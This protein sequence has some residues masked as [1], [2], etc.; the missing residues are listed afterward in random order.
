M[1][2]YAYTG[3]VQNVIFKKDI[4]YLVELWGADSINSGMA[5]YANG[6]I[7]CPSDTTLYLYVG[8]SPYHSTNPYAGGWNG[9]GAGGSVG[10]ST[11]QTSRGYGGGGATDLRTSTSTS[12]VQNYKILVAG[13]AGG[14][15]E[16]GAS[17]GGVGE[18][19]LPYPQQVDSD[20]EKH[21]CGGTFATESAEGVGGLA[22][23][24]PSY[25]GTNDGT[26]YV[27]SGGG[28]G[29]GYYGGGGGSTGKVYCWGSART[30][31]AGTAGNSRG[32]GGAGGSMTTGISA[33]GVQGTGGGGGGGSD[34][35]KSTYSY[36]LG[37]ATSM[38][39]G[40]RPQRP[41]FDTRNGMASV[42]P[43]LS[44]P[45]VRN[46][47]REG[48]FI[49]VTV[50]KTLNNG[51][52][53]LFYADGVNGNSQG[54]AGV[55]G[56]GVPVKLIGTES[57]TLRYS[58]QKGTTGKR[59]FTFTMTNG[60][61]SLLKTYEYTISATAPT[62][63]FNENT[64]SSKLMQ[65]GI[66]ENVFRVSTPYD[67]IDYRSES[68]LIIDDVEYPYVFSQG[69][70]QHTIQLPYLYDGINKQTY[71]LKIKT[72]AC[73][74]AQSAYG[75]G[76]DIWS[77]WIETRE[78]IVYA[79]A[80]QKNNLI[81]STVLK[82]RAVE[83]STKINVA[84]KEKRVMGLS[85]KEYRLM[86]YDGDNI[87]QTFDTPNPSINVVMDYPHNRYYRFGVSIL[88][89]GF[90]SEVVYSD[91]FFI[92][93]I[94]SS[95]VVLSNDLTITTSIEQTFDKIEVLV[96]DET[97]I[98]S[99]ENLNEKLPA[100]FFSNGNNDVEVKI[101]ATDAD[102]VSHKYRVHIT[103]DEESLKPTKVL[104]IK[105]TVSINGQEEYPVK[106]VNK[107]DQAIDLGVAEKEMS[108][109]G[110]GGG[111]IEEVTQRITITKIN[112]EMS[113]N[114]RLVEILG[115]IE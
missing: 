11:D 89:N 28:G 114:A 69:V 110:I 101:Y 26:Y 32:I 29:G 19:G 56:G 79:V 72:R 71:R 9:G 92:T 33:T 51:E 64:L 81:F 67:G 96:N 31:G 1:A 40:I 6:I 15:T 25:E 85:D 41:I 7:Q 77:D 20:G 2:D 44:Q 36:F 12:S 27:P 90:L 108:A 4:K 84:W 37:G 76:K 55:V 57:V 42:H 86:L 74:T 24:R 45:E 14:G 38:S 22:P 115:A 103:Y 21:D 18:N 17:G 52:E 39:S 13:G 91:S 48:D 95:S 75:T 35:Y 104:D 5:G 43:I 111:I 98:L 94:N 8:G 62:V 53:E 65:G 47:T 60:V 83:K 112:Q 30:F 50:G 58:I 68:V 109:I 80:P 78:L 10:I 102:F 88:I 23:Y 105:S 113:G 82:D 73:Q 63:S 99:R 70:G 3:S 106:L 66:V 100:W 54:V 59:V 34:H 49:L 107:A 61:D 16:W 93:D 97:R 87:V 46:I